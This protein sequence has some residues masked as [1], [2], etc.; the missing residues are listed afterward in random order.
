[1]YCAAEIVPASLSAVRCALASRNSRTRAS[2]PSY[3]SYPE[4]FSSVGVE[5]AVQP[6]R[7]CASNCCFASTCSVA[8]S[9]ASFTKIGTPETCRRRRSQPSRRGAP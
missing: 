7:R 1:M 2:S 3:T 4:T 8:A 6:A 9:A 5:S